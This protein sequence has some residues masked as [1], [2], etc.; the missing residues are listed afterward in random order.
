L[1]LRIL[2]E[3][4]QHVDERAAVDRI[5]ADAHA[6]R[7]A[8]AQC[9]HLG[10][11]LVAE[12]PGPCDHAHRPARVDVTRHDAHHRAARADHAGAVRP[13]ERRP[14]I[15]GVTPQVPLHPNHVLRGNAIGDRHDEADAGVRG[16]HDR[17]GAEGRGNEDETGGGA[18][19]LHRL[20]DRVEHR[21]PQVLAAALPRRD[22]AHDVR[23]IGDHFPG[24]ERPLVAGEALDDD[25]RLLVEQDAHAASPASRAATTRSAASE[26]VSAVWICRPLSLRMRRPSSTLVPARRTTR[27]TGTRTSRTACTTPCA[28]QSHRLI[29]ANTFTRMARTFLSERTR[30]NAAATRS[31]LAPPPISRNFAGSPPACLIMSMVAIA[32]PAPL[33]M[34]PISPSNAT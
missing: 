28:T 10:C 24:V 22:A 1:R 9:L 21:P 29:P 20:L 18:R 15:P 34:Q 27:G 6:R 32:R 23:A 5:A 8:D 17:V 11:R 4:G 3:E 19:A 16:L 7:N 14:P 26:S 33:M 2:L 13:D 31:G 12:R 30:R 25:P